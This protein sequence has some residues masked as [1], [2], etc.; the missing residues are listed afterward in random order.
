MTSP[1]LGV[2]P[3]SLLGPAAEVATGSRQNPESAR[4]RIGDLDPRPDWRSGPRPGK[5]LVRGR[6]EDSRKNHPRPDDTVSVI[7][8]VAAAGRER[9]GRHVAVSRHPWAPP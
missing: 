8:S 4:G 7:V 1:K 5:D 9:Q 3:I 6:I 2:K